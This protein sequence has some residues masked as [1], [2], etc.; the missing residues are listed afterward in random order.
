[1]AALEA[2]IALGTLGGE[3][4]DIV[5]ACPTEEFGF[6]AH[7]VR[8][9]FGGPPPLI[10]PPIEPAGAGAPPV[11]AAPNPTPGPDGGAQPAGPGPGAAPVAPG[12]AAAGPFPQTAPP[13]DALPSPGPP[14]SPPGA[15]VAAAPA[16]GGQ[17]IVSPPGTDFPRRAP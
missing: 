11:G 14:P 4:L 9:P 10:A 5:V 3:G 8:E 6:R 15:P 17:I 2:A 12:A 16:S 7:Q 1:M 13:R